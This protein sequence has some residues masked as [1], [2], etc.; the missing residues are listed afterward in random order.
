MREEWGSQCRAGSTG[1]HEPGRG[2][3]IEPG[4][5]RNEHRRPSICAFDER[6][7]GRARV[8]AILGT[9]HDWF[10]GPRRVARGRRLGGARRRAGEETLQVRRRAGEKCD[11]QQDGKSALHAYRFEYIV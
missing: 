10:G 5:R 8:G 1:V 3:I 6:R 9:A 7:R 11:E 2:G 4:R